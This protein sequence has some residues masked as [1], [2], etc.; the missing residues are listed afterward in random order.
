MRD[1]DGDHE[2]DDAPRHPVADPSPPEQEQQSGSADREGSGVGLVE[3]TDR[4]DEHLDQVAAGFGDS[5]QGGNLTDDDRQG[6]TEHEAGHDRFRQ[7]LGE[8]RDPQ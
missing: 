6:Q 2:H 8:P 1:H 7:E 3:V 5:Q 4:A